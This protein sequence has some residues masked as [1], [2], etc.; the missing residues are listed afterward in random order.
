[1]VKDWFYSLL[2]KIN[3][4]YGSF[5]SQLIH[6]TNTDPVRLLSVAVPLEVEPQL[7]NAVVE[8]TS[9][10]SVELL[11]ILNRICGFSR[12]QFVTERLF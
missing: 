5:L 8:L 2:C 3:T 4:W 7:K 11:K 10:A 6:Q 1:M 12:T 9:V